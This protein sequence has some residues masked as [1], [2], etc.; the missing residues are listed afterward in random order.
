VVSDD[1]EWLLSVGSAT[2]TTASW[3]W[4]TITMYHI[5]LAFL[6]GDIR[7]PV[8]GLYATTET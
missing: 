3:R 6:S 5:V 8:Q 7:M 4:Q 2:A 1:D